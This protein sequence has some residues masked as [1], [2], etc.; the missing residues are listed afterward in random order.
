MSNVSFISGAQVGQM[1]MG[2]YQVFQAYSDDVLDYDDALPVFQSRKLADCHAAAQARN[3][4]TG[5][6]FT[7]IQVRTGE[8]R[9]SYGFSAAARKTK[10]YDDY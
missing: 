9:G 6:P 2:F 7:I 4:T 8:C 1:P 10:K 5:C 3:A